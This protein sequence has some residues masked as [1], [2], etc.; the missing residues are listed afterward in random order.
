MRPVDKVALKVQKYLKQANKQA[1]NREAGGGVRVMFSL[2]LANHLQSAKLA[3]QP[4]HLA[5]S[6][7]LDNRS[8]GGSGRRRGHTP[9][10]H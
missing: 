8:R 2:Q 6:S 1:S 9:G 10:H 4:G 7:R 3:G 5:P